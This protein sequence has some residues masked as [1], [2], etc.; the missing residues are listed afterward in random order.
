MSPYSFSLTGAIF[1]STLTWNCR[2]LPYTSPAIDA[3]AITPHKVA[4][5]PFGRHHERDARI[6]PIGDVDGP[7]EERVLGDELAHQHASRRPVDPE[8]PMG[9]QIPSVGRADHR[10]RL[11]FLVLNDPDVCAGRR[12]R[13]RHDRRL[14]IVGPLER[15]SRLIARAENQQGEDRHVHRALHVADVVAGALVTICSACAAVEDE[16]CR[17]NFTRRSLRSRTGLPSTSKTS[18]NWI[19]DRRRSAGRGQVRLQLPVT[20]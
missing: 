10:E 19:Y 20:G 4:L 16:G 8:A 1:S 6:Q 15:E 12:R 3:A 11:Y 5:A 14:G 18:R 7:R 9:G 2:N 13:V 17:N